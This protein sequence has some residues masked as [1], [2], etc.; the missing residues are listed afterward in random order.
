VAIRYLLDT[1]TAGCII[2]GSILSVQR[3]LVKVP[4]AQIAIS[5]VSDAELR[6]GV[7]SRRHA[8]QMA[9]IVKDSCSVCRFFPGTHKE[10][11]SR[12]NS[13]PRSSARVSRWATSTR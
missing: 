1:N 13:A 9:T 8:T 6:Y 5:T 2:K 7:A 12:D 4:T 3:R 11:K 10:R